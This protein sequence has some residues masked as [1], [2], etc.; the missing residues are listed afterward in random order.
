[1]HTVIIVGYVIQIRTQTG[2]RVE[3][4]LERFVINDSI[5]WGDRRCDPDANAILIYLTTLLFEFHC[6]EIMIFLIVNR[7]AGRP[8]TGFIGGLRRPC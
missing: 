1:M 7:T 4:A 3:N 5:T 6:C 8:G 2:K